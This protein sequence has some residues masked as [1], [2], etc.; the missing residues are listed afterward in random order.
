[1]TIDKQEIKTR[2]EAKEVN[3]SAEAL[4]RKA[5]SIARLKEEGVPFIDHLPVIDDSQLALRRTVEEIASRAIALHI[6]ALKGEVLEQPLVEEL[7]EDF[8]ANEFLSPREK[9]FCEDLHPSEI[10]RVQFCWRYESCSALYH[11]RP[12]LVSWMMCFRFG[13][14]ALNGRF[15]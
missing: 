9:A 2:I 6:V 1:M 5:R 8:G 4:A 10:D 12:S 7:V 13:N 3:P 14:C 15:A 11:D